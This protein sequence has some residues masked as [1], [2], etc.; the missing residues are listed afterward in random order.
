[1]RFSPTLE[2]S[3]SFDDDVSAF[4]RTSDPSGVLVLHDVAI[5]QVP[6]T[7]PTPTS[8][9]A[10][11]DV[12]ERSL[13]AVAGL[14]GE[15]VGYLPEHGGVLVQNLVPTRHGAD[16]QIS[17]SSRVTLEFHTETAF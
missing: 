4:R 7:P 5:G 6:S 10:K 13:L 14:L 15:A 16:R 17:T 8:P 11:D 1:M 9:T 3:I 2:R 12:S